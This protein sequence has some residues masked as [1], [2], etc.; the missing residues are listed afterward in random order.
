MQYGAKA[1][2]FQQVR[3]IKNTN[4]VPSAVS[5]I[6]HLEIKSVLFY[7]INN[8]VQLGQYFRN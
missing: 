4:V 8:S 3:I 6:L 5:H 2:Q 1:M 7:C